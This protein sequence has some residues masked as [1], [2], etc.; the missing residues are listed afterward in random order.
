MAGVD[1]CT[2]AQLMGR[3]TIQMT[4]RYAHLAP[5]R[6]QLAIDRL[7]SS[8]ELVP[9]SV[10]SRRSEKRKKVATSTK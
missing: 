5:E 2:V 4:M 9:K 10:T 7:V 8:D 3:A 1:I 6:E